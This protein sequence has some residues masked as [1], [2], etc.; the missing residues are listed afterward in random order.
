MA[1]PIIW[2]NV[3]VN[4]QSAIGAAATITGITRA[5]PGVVTTSQ[6]HNLSAG[7]IV[8]IEVRTKTKTGFKTTVVDS[9]VVMK[10]NGTLSVTT[11]KLRK[12]QTLRVRV[13]NQLLISKKL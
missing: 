12:G 8:Y 6:A 10:E 4:M 1:T 7:D 5:N 9:F 13:G 2:K 3:A 11:K